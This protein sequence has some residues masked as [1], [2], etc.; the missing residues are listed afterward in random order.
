MNKNYLAELKSL[1]INISTKSTVAK[2]TVISC[3]APVFL[4]S[5]EIHM[6]G[7]IG[8]F[9]YMR[10]GRIGGGLKSVGRYC[11]IAPGITVGDSNHAVNWLSTHPFQ[12]GASTIFKNWT[13]RKDHQFLKMKHTKSP[14]TVIGNDVWIGANV[15][16]M[17]G[18]T[19][20][21]GAVVG[22]GSVVTKDVPAYAIVAGVPAKIIRF[23][24]DE[25]TI[26]KLLDLKWW[27][28][29]ADS[30]L[31]V[32]FDEIDTAIAQIKELSE[33]GSL[34]VINR[35]AIRVIGSELVK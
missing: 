22:A 33:S 11:S 32:Q 28:F 17:P 5:M 13:K 18:V 35:E 19:I 15:T 26:K 30:L 24:F 14:N 2:T 34:E 7:S 25:N 16:I 27:R 29:E 9:S 21:D 3:E 12:Y 20:A 8:A 31:G 4:S 23:R 1:G 10:G 6:I